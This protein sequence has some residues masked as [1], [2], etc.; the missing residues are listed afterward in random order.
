M[1]HTL[2]EIQNYFEGEDISVVDTRDDIL[3]SNVGDLIL[4]IVVVISLGDIAEG[5]NSDDILGDSSADIAGR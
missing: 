5:F 3:K 4:L 1:Y 2:I